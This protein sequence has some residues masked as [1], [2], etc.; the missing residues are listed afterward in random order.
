MQNTKYFELE[1]IL[2]HK[3]PMI[4]IHKVIE[5]DLAERTLLAEMQITADSLFFDSGLGGV[6]ASFGLE[7]MAQSVGA[8]SG[9]A[10]KETG[11]AIIVF[12]FILGTRKYQ[13]NI[14]L[15]YPASYYIAV[16]EIFNGGELA[17]FFSEIKN[18]AGQAIASAELNLFKPQDPAKF[19]K[20]H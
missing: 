5:Y 4:L 15:F 19:I 8:F 3:K 13:N 10:D 2:P 14:D 1:E 18:S 6:P 7:Y 9:I 17:C 16:K 20:E 11:A 12:G